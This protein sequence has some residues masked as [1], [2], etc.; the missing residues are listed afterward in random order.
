LRRRTLGA[1]DAQRGIG[2]WVLSVLPTLCAFLLP[3]LSWADDSSV[4][5]AKQVFSVTFACAGRTSEGESLPSFASSAEAKFEVTATFGEGAVVAL[6]D[7]ETS[8]IRQPLYDA[9][10][11]SGRLSFSD[12]EETTVV[13]TRMSGAD[14]AL[15]GE[16][17][18]SDGDV[19][20]LTI[21]QGSDAT[22]RLFV[23]FSAAPATLFHGTCTA[24]AHR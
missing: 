15:V 21:E 23:L 18:M 10:S 2:L 17:I 3:S 20:G 7:P 11:T 13:W 9:E 19:L 4:T 5:S 6:V 1:D 16:A 22:Q 14:G 12:G 24:A 8:A